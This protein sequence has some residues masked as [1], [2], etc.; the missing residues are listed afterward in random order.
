V[1]FISCAA[2]GLTLPR[3][4]LPCPAA[5]STGSS[6]ARFPTLRPSLSARLFCRLFSVYALVNV[7]AGAASVPDHHPCDA[8]EPCQLPR[9][10]ARTIK[11]PGQ[12]FRAAATHRVRR[13]C[14]VCFPLSPYLRF[15]RPCTSFKHSTFRVFA[16]FCTLSYQTSIRSSNLHNTTVNEPLTPCRFAFPLY[17]R[18][19]IHFLAPCFSA[20]GQH[21]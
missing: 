9:R 6:A 14:C 20:S 5:R 8:H 16:A 13:A 18:M 21:L 19:Y 17:I 10:F 3:P 1:F 4:V 12:A 11:Q 7:P 2:G 15:T